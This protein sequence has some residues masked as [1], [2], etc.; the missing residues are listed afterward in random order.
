MFFLSFFDITSL[1][2]NYGKENSSAMEQKFAD[3]INAAWIW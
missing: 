2:R 1:F 3:P